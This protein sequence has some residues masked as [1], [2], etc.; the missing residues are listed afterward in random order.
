MAPALSPSLDLYA[1]IKRAPLALVLKL[2]AGPELPGVALPGW[3]TSA[4]ESPTLKPETPH[5]R[6]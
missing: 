6:D 1:A 5:A 4:P 3:K 2:A